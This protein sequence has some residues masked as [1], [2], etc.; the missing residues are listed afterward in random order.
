MILRIDP[1]FWSVTAAPWLAFF[2]YLLMF[3]LH[4]ARM[5]DKVPYR[6]TLDGEACEWVA[7]PIWALLSPLTLLLLILL[8]AG[9]PDEMRLHGFLLTF[10]AIYGLV[11]GAFVAI[12]RSA[13][14]KTRRIYAIMLTAVLTV[15]AAGTA[16]CH[17]MGTW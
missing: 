12:D 15:P 17:W 13:C 7:K 16:I 3:G 6:F 5:P 8:L 2:A 10:W 4:Y 11:F 9:A 1:W 14:T